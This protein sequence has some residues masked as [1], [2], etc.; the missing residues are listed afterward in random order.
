MRRNLNQKQMKVKV[1]IINFVFCVF[2]FLSCV[3]SFARGETSIKELSIPELI[4][5]LD[6]EDIFVREEAEEELLDRFSE[7]VNEV[8]PHSPPHSRSLAIFDYLKEV[9]G[10]KNEYALHYSRRILGEFGERSLEAL[11][12]LLEAL[13]SEDSIV[14]KNAG[15]FLQTVGPRAKEALP[16]LIKALEREK[17]LE[18]RKE[19]VLCLGI[20]DSDG[21]KTVPCLVELLRN[22]NIEIEKAVV[23]S[24]GAIGDDAEDAV[25]P[26]IKLLK[27]TGDNSL[28]YQII[29]SFESIKSKPEETVPV[30]ISFLK[31]KDLKL[32]R[33]SVYAL[34][35]YEEKA[36]EAIPAL[37]RALGDEDLVTRRHSLRSL[38]SI[39]DI[40]VPDIMGALKSKDN[41][42]REYSAYILGELKAEEAIPALKKLLKDRDVNVRYYAAL[43]LHK[44]GITN[45]AVKKALKEYI[46]QA[47]DASPEIW[48]DTNELLECLTPEK[49][50][51]RHSVIKELMDYFE[52]AGLKEGS[53]AADIGAGT[54]YFTFYFARRVGPDGRVY[55]V[56]VQERALEYIEERLE[57]KKLNPH[58]NIKC[59]LNKMDDVCLPDESVDF[60]Y[61]CATSIALA[62][63][64]FKGKGMIKSVWQAL[65]KGG[66]LV[67]IDIE[68]AKRTGNLRNN[69][70]KNY[71]EAGFKFI[72]E[73]DIFRRNKP[74]TRRFLLLFEK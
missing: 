65:K 54:G 17:D 14:R 44:M 38:I 42:V 33:I 18:A 8:S 21:E 43:S 23:R 34:R 45:S 59:V 9:L 16:C 7:E 35:R 63:E 4:Q 15:F 12:L 55:A 3:S 40:C 73:S 64:I 31:N 70:I 56:D 32:R 41:R 19:M 37:I 62:P 28:K 24:L 47:P 60:G 46:A 67:V 10:T 61:I 58:K 22:E 49:I 5:R 68:D 26:L 53:T 2:V 57:D 1:L 27:K 6:D 69:V 29:R 52:K 13:N 74:T 25:G 20:I 11:P 72:E 66:K 39:G 30:L 36:E 51:Y 48:D 71:T 50:R